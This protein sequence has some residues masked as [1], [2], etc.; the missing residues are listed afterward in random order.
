MYARQHS[1]ANPVTRLF[2]RYP[3]IPLDR[4]H[5]CLVSSPH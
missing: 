1:G 3:L 5:Q 2:R 4:L